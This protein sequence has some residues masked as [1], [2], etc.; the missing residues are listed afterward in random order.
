MQG[1]MDFGADLAFWDPERKHY[2]AYIR[3]WRKAEPGEETLGTP[4]PS[5]GYRQIL[6]SVSEDFLNWSPPELVT[7]ESGPL[8]HYYTNGVRPYF[9]APHIYFGLPKRFLPD[10]THANNRMP[11][12]SDGVFM[13]SRDGKR[14]RRWSEAFIRPG[15]QRQRWVNRNNMPACGIVQTKSALAGSPPEL[16]VYS[17]EGYY[18]GESCQIRR[19]SLRL[20]GF[21]SAHANSQGGE[22]VTRPLTFTGKELRINFAT[23]APGTVLVEL[24]TP[25]RQA[26]PGYSLDECVEIYGDS[27]DQVVRWQDGTNVAALAQQPVRIRFV[28]RDADLYSFRFDAG[29][30]DP[31]N[32]TP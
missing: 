14:F 23:S 24:Q 10:R 5:R 31:G 30:T 9:R 16:S 18:Q 22:L 29:E 4:H 7:Y 28:L 1:A 20:D 26:I 11:G 12:L 2:V 8:Q 6:R 21:V 13:S 32:T 3:G 27:V 15:A 17:T 25:A 19:H